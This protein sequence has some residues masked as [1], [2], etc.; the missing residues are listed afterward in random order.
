LKVRPLRN[1]ISGSRNPEMGS[2]ETQPVILMRA[3]GNPGIFVEVLLVG[4]SVIARN[5]S[6]FSLNTFLKFMT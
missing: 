3:K 5:F 6:T 4:L 1:T 2:D